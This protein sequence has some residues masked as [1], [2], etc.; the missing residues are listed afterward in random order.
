MHRPSFSA[1]VLSNLKLAKMNKAIAYIALKNWS[2]IG[3]SR[4]KMMRNRVKDVSE[5]FERSIDDLKQ[6][7]PEL[8][9]ATWDVDRNLLLEQ[10]EKVY[11]RCVKEEIEVL[12]WD[13]ENYP[14]RF[15]SIDKTPVA[16]Y[17]KGSAR[18]NGRRTVGIVGTRGMTERGELLCEKLVADLAPYDPMII[19]GLAYGID[20]T[21]HI[22]A[23]KNGLDT[24][25]MMG[26]GPDLIYPSS[27]KNTA[28]KMMKQGGLMT[29]LDFGLGPEREHFPMRNQLIAAMSDALVVVESKAK[30][31]SMITAHLAI[32]MKKPL[33]T[34]PGRPTDV[35]SRG[36][37]ALIK[38]KK[39]Q[40]I[41]SADD[42]IEAMSW[43]PIDREIS[44][45]RQL[46]VELTEMEQ[47]ILDVLRSKPD[48]N[49][50]QLSYGVSLPMHELSPLLLE[51]EF[52]GLVKSLPGNRYLA[53]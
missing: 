43:P 34:F 48:L 37:N 26:T 41:E 30:G 35:Q 22:S 31:G 21:S 33:F 14:L 2:T 40:L 23:L 49:I 52:K 13:H 3:P 36:C 45:Q 27:H 24:I 10:A 9:L 42:L 29:E 1:P 19:S 38:D 15:K 16:V 53:I 12:H 50:D 44:V 39:A 51:L 8:P 4:A 20:V 46:F 5:L 47:K 6:L 18:L 32:D 17:F 11:N 25:A 7:M 28:A